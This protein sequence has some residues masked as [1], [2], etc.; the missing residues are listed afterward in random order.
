MYI[1]LCISMYGSPLPLS[2]YFYLLATL[3]RFYF[4]IVYQDIKGSVSVLFPLSL[5][6]HFV[7]NFIFIFL[8]GTYF[9]SRCLNSLMLHSQN[10]QS[11]AVTPRPILLTLSCL[12]DSKHTQTCAHTYTKRYR[13]SNTLRAAI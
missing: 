8:S 13:F 6:S 10:L 7:F 12:L 3:E 4:L 9:K 5:H 2:P 11:Q 1:Y